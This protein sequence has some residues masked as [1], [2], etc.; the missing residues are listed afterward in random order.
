MTKRTFTD[1]NGSRVRL[2]LA[3]IRT[4]RALRV[5]LDLIPAGTVGALL[6]ADETK[7]TARC[8]FGAVG[9]VISLDDIEAAL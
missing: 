8:W 7:R 5:G 6:D 9:V 4:V 2:G 3:S 1:S